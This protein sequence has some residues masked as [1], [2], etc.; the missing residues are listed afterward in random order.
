[1][2]ASIKPKEWNHPKPIAIQVREM[3]SNK[4]SSPY[5]KGTWEHSTHQDNK[6]AIASTIRIDTIRSIHKKMKKEAAE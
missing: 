2:T 4:R 1:M 6:L 3:S 5:Y